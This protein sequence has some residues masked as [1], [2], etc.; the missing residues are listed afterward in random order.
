MLNRKTVGV[1][2]DLSLDHLGI[3]RRL[4]IA[5]ALIAGELE[6]AGR[7]V[8]LERLEMPLFLLAGATDH[9]TPPDQVFALADHAST[10]AE[11]IYRD[12]VPGGHLGLFMGRQALRDY[13]PPLL[14]QVMRFNDELRQQLRA[15]K[16]VLATIRDTRALGDETE[17]QLRQAIE[18]FKSGFDVRE[19]QTLAGTAA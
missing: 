9:I 8:A 1:Y 2:L 17:A 5:N 12:V 11:L 3:V 4:F 19:E 16:D 14:E 13:W 10:P 15:Q 6:V 18:E 7:K